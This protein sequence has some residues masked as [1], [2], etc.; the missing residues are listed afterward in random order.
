MKNALRCIAAFACVLTATGASAA[1]QIDQV[2]SNADG[3]VQYV[4]LRETAGA[5]GLGGFN[6]LQLVATHGSV[7][8]TYTFVGN[9][10]SNATANAHVLIATA[11]FAALG[12][13]TPDYVLPD[14]FIPTDGG[15]LTF[16]GDHLAYAA[17]PTDGV[18]GIARS[19][20]QLPNLATNFAGASASAPPLPVTIVE[21]VDPARGHYFISGLAPDI[22]AL[23][24]GR[25]PGWQRTGQSFLGYPSQDS[26]GPGATP[27]CRFYIPPELGDSHFFSASPAECAAVLQKMQFDPAY[28]GYVFETP[29]AFFIQLPDLASGVCPPGTIA[30]FRLWNGR[31]DS[32]HRYTTS[33]AIKAQ[34]IAL[35]FRSEGYGPDGV[36]MCAPTNGPIDLTFVNINGVV[37]TG[38]LFVAVASAQGGQGLIFISRDGV[39]WS[40]RSSGTPSLRG[41]LWSGSEIL[42][43]GAGGTIVTSP[44]G[45]RWNAQVSGV[46]TP[47]NAAAWS[48]TEFRV[49]GDGG[50]ML[51]SPDGV[52]WSPRVSKTAVNLNGIVWSGAKYVLVGDGGTIL[53]VLLSG[54]P[55]ARVSGTAQN[56]EAVGAA[57][58]GRIVAVGAQGTILT[59]TDGINWIVRNSGTNASLRGV[60][61]SDTQIVVVGTGGRILT[62]TNG[63]NWAVQQSRTAMDLDGIAWSG[64]L[65]AAVGESGTIDTSP[66]GTIWTLVP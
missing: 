33:L 62:S 15:T 44:D 52:S 23:D 12:L 27:V 56:L 21:Y 13:V 20:A 60:V 5:N 17:L 42:A 28:A 49:V 11:G 43:V 30:V 25:I 34:M 31:V 50:V 40:L 1:F 61:S 54:T 18:N 63:T 64:G 8:K 51:V 36:A 59:S 37:W 47:L 14:R 29:A 19:G 57:A 39:T 45:Y 16:A 65:F 35:G 22:D 41:I 3:A 53:T 6:G 32:N 26:G 38:S 9:L 10:P 7:V 4:V 2:Y 48:G 55:T 58:N 24:S 66:D 46:G